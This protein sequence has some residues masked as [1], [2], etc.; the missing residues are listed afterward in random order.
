MPS[1]SRP[2]TNLVPKQIKCT[3]LRGGT[4]RAPTFLLS[5]ILAL[6]PNYRPSSSN[7]TSPLADPKLHSILTHLLPQI[8][9]TGDPLQVDGVGGGQSVT[10]KAAIVCPSP[11]DGVDVDYLFAQVSILGEG[12][13]SI[14]DFGSNC[15]NVMAAVGIFAWE[16]GMH[17]GNTS[18][19][20]KLVVRNVNMNSVS[21]IHIAPPLSRIAC[22]P[23][24]HVFRGPN[25][26]HVSM[27]FP[28]IHG[29]K[30]G[31]VLPTSRPSQII[32]G[33]RVSLVDA[34]TVVVFLL[35]SEWGFETSAGWNTKNKNMLELQKGE[36][37]A[38]R[39]EAGRLM[40]M[41]DVSNSVLPKVCLV[42]SNEHAARTRSG[43]P[44]DQS[45]RSPHKDCDISLLYLTPHA[46]HMTI[47]VTGALC[48][49]VA[50]STPDTLPYLCVDDKLGT[51][52]PRKVFRVGHPCGAME[53]EPIRRESDGAVLGGKVVRTASVIFEGNVSV[54]VEE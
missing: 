43:S 1:K 31:K 5:S 10:S 32:R 16:N 27:A 48:T 19:E 9:G 2:C 11:E 14:V 53:L 36:I 47:A 33:K 30:T 24:S 26:Y 17:S 7:S 44:V 8:L 20:R 21:E 18:S 25:E 23:N 41:G 52:S 46:P 34:A 12:P 50:S 6:Y 28:D 39:K 13:Q 49:L 54:W 51:R 42:S 3:L 45:P 22:V 38:I 35:A 37:E 29:L 4:S 15:G 40:G